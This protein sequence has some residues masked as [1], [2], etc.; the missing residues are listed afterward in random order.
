[1]K[2]LNQ[3]IEENKYNAPILEASILNVGEL[4]KESDILMRIKDLINN[5]II[6]VTNGGKT[7]ED[8]F[9]KFIK[10]CKI[11]G[12]TVNLEKGL[13]LIVH[14]P[15]DP[16][17]NFGFVFGEIND[18]VH[19][20]AHSGKHCVFPV[21]YLPQECKLMYIECVDAK[22]IEFDLSKHPDKMMGNPTINFQNYGSQFFTK[23]VWNTNPINTLI[24]GVKVKDDAIFSLPKIEE[25][26][27]GKT[28]IN[29]FMNRA[30]EPKVIKSIF[31]P[32]CEIGTMR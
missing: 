9:N 26:N 3:Y 7:K 1:M 23:F 19:Y 18:Q 11:H 5:E 2:T 16:K 24:F 14:I 20:R 13:Y 31:G 27:P 30:M 15:N 12:N 4:T 6:E 8:D 10:H 22:T 32:N 29:Y 21:K 17:F 28:G 25:F